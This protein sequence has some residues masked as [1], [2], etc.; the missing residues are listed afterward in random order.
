MRNK[1]SSIRNDASSMRNKAS[2]VRIKASS[3]KNEKTGKGSA[4][5]A[6]I[7]SEFAV[8]PT[9][10]SSETVSSFCASTANSMGSLFITSRA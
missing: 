7:H 2:S 8:Y 3:L 6:G 4:L 5:Y 10:P 1:T 9:P